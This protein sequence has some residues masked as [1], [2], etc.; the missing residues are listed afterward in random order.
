[1]IIVH[2]V[3][4]FAAGIA[5]FVKSLADAMPDDV[6]II[7]HG[8]RKYVM[9][10]SEVKKFFPKANVRFIRWASAQRAINPFRDS[11]AFSELYKI[12]RRL[13]RAGLVDAVHL[14]SSKAGLLGRIACRLAGINNVLYTPNGASFL[15]AK[16]RVMSYTYRMLERFGNGMGGKVV[17]CSASELKAYQ[18]L[19][20]KATYINNG[21]DA[22]KLDSASN[23]GSEGKFRIITS[24]RIVSQKHPAMFNEIAG[25]FEE[26]D[27]FE[28]IWAGDG[29]DKNVLTAKNISVTGWMEAEDVKK[30][31]ASSDL[32]LSTSLYE[33]L[34]FAV[35]EA[36]AL[37]KPVLLSECVGNVDAVKTGLNGDLFRSEADAVVKIMKYYNN[38]DMCE[39]M[40]EFSQQ[41]CVTE[42]DVHH[43]LRGYRELYR[44]LDHLKAIKPKWSFGI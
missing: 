3:E 20:I 32:Y 8:E 16:N 29:P 9:S 27:Q 38:P 35:L 30:M 13:K 25:Y 31:V 7:V 23:K 15:S 19:G 1:M 5:V 10:A 39:V 26:F 21:I 34:S 44:G 37:R 24:G 41:I 11:L 33:G 36:L 17:C 18:R 22:R 4:P 28:F 12:L 6:H 40:G 43:N 2:V 14:H 42:F